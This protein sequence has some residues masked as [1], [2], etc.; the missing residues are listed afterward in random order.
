MANVLLSFLPPLVGLT[1]V[2]AVVGAGMVRIFGRT[3]NQS[4][5]K[6]VKRQIQAG[7]LELRLFVDEP[8]ISLRAQRA[9]L[10]ANLRYLAFALRPALWMTVPVGLLLIHLAAFYEHAPLPLAEPAVVTMQMNA[11]WDPSGPPP[12][13]IAPQGV[14]ILGPP[15]RVEATREVSWRV[16]P[17]FP[18]SRMLQFRFNRET[19]SKVMEAGEPQRYVPGRTVR[20]EWGLISSPGEGRLQAGFAEWIEIGYPETDFRVFGA[21]VNWLV[22][23]LV[24]S[25]VAGLFLRKRFDVVI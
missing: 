1:C 16:M 4:G 17:L 3:S 24:V 13:L 8:G 5:M 11:A 12:E 14:A 7:L 9:L 15:V 22:W 21:R 6:Q 18:G 23:F 25:M 10:V 20:S 19:V 2:A